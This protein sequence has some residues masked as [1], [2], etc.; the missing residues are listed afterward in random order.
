[1]RPIEAV[2][3]AEVLEAR[4]LLAAVSDEGFIEA[5]QPE[6]QEAENLVLTSDEGTEECLPEAS[7][8]SEVVG[9]EEVIDEE[10]RGESASVDPGTEV[11][12]LDGVGDGEILVA[13]EPYEY[14]V[15]DKADAETEEFM[16]TLVICEF[17]E[18]LWSRCPDDVEAETED[19]N[20]VYE[21]QDVETLPWFESTGEP[22][23]AVE[24]L[25]S[26]G[27]WDWHY[28]L[29]TVSGIEGETE[30][31]AF[32]GPENF[33]VS[34]TLLIENGGT[35]EGTWTEFVDVGSEVTGDIAPDDTIS[36]EFQSEEP[37]LWSRDRDLPVSEEYEPQMMLFSSLRGGSGVVL[38]ALALSVPDAA[39]QISSS[40]LRSN[41]VPE[42]RR[43]ESVFAGREGAVVLT[44]DRVADSRLVSVRTES[45]AATPGT[46]AS[47]VPRRSTPLTGSLIDSA[48]PKEAVLVNERDKLDIFDE[49]SAT[50]DKKRSRGRQSPTESRED[51]PVPRSSETT[52]P[53]ASRT[54]SDH[55]DSGESVTV[56]V[57]SESAAV[58]GLATG[59]H[60]PR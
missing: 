15:P 48:T 20:V 29:S 4:R 51:P 55:V 41:F 36:M 19:W 21:T 33:D 30:Y 12:F 42:Q 23:T 40:A 56:S 46:A 1:L 6:A 28:D 11:T 14:F 58:S 45:R 31:V 17:P 50:E 7:T 60:V 9:V 8:E 43:M 47:V 18:E 39:P 24:D 52:G 59:K 44:G 57:D 32:G 5:P 53:G 27:E 22:A 35:D 25:P 2:Q 13:E 10:Q 34:E 26:T 37:E 16:P 54:S 3:I 38:R 49:G